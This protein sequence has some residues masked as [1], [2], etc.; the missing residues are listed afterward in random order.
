MLTRT[1]FIKLA[2]AIGIGAGSA[3][4]IHA[5]TVVTPPSLPVSQ[6]APTTTSST[7][8]TQDPTAAALSKLSNEEAQLQSELSSAKSALATRLP[9]PAIDN[10]NSNAAFLDG[11]S[12]TTTSIPPPVVR[13]SSALSAASWKASFGLIG[14]L[15]VRL[16]YGGS[17]RTP[18]CA[19]DCGFGVITRVV[20]GP[21]IGFG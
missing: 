9:S 13:T 10:A 21:V 11:H 14:D 12:T 5:V 17:C 4:A 2:A 6:V 8:T 18:N 16:V 3:T 19:G 7:T 20:R 15:V 1:G